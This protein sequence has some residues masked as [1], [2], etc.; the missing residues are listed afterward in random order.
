[1]SRVGRDVASVLF[2]KVRQV[3]VTRGV[4]EFHAGRPVIVT[5]KHKCI[6][7]LPID[8]LNEARLAEFVA[9]CAPVSPSLAITARRAHA[10]GVQAEAATLVR[11]TDTVGVDAIVSLATGAKP[12]VQF[13]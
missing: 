1:M 12:D 7:A 10:L 5:G 13:H 9:L 11:F 6:L 3:G 2:G 8:G 4:A